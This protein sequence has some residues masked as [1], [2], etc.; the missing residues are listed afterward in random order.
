M[1]FEVRVSLALDTQHAEQAIP[2]L[3]ILGS[4]LGAGGGVLLGAWVFTVSLSAMLLPGIAQAAELLR[5]ASG[6]RSPDQWR[7]SPG[8]HSLTAAVVA[9]GGRGFAPPTNRQGLT[10]TLADDPR[11]RSA[12][13]REVHKSPKRMYRWCVWGS[14]LGR[15]QNCPL[16]LESG[17]LTAGSMAEWVWST[18]AAFGEW[19]ASLSNPASRHEWC[20]RRVSE[21]GPGGQA[22]PRRSSD[23][24]SRIL[25]S[26]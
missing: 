24:S 1:T 6:D 19:I 17:A 3:T 9:V 20:S 21:L 26:V 8:V 16:E 15:L 14:L 11:R 18:D 7:H 13:R 10:Q 12:H 2:G 23:L 5:V 4:A 22:A 25:M